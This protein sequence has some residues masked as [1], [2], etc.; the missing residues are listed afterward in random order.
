MMFLYKSKNFWTAYAPAKL[1]LFFEVYGKRDDGFHEIIS[2]AVPIR[3]FDT[4]IF[5]PTEKEEIDF[6]CQNASSDVPD[7]EN[8]FVVRAIRLLQKRVGMIRGA[9]IRLFK[10][11]PSQSGLGGGSSDAATALQTARHVW[12]LNISDEELL[13]IAAEIGSDCPI[14][15]HR[16]AS[17]SYGRGEKIRSIDGFI[18]KLYFVILKPCEGLSTA[19]VYK[20]CM[21]CHDWQFQYPEKL[22]TELKNGDPVRIGQCCFNRLENPAQ[23]VWYPFHQF[24]QELEKFDCLT[25]RM[26]GSGTAFYGLCRNARHATCVAGRLRQRVTKNDH[27]F[28]ASN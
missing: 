27:I 20:Q 11:I 6:S 9:K 28:I 7:N 12:N 15:F 17:I 4:L 3:L 14:F 24:K 23:A 18:P 21:S 8:N 25:V 1:N 19:T 16:N 5:E 2:I 26:S 22:I 10:R 13:E